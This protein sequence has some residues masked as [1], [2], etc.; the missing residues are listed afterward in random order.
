MLLLSTAV[1]L[2]SFSCKLSCNDYTNGRMVVQPFSQTSAPFVMSASYP[3]VQAVCSNEILLS[4]YGIPSKDTPH[5][6]PSK[7]APSPRSARMKYTKILLRPS[8]C[9]HR[10]PVCKQ[11]AMKWRRHFVE[12]CRCM[13]YMRVFTALFRFPQNALNL[14]AMTH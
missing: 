7:D 13:L 3:S 8:S 2:F 14:D 6:I 12:K 4:T 5:G 11:S 1:R 9:Q 10:I